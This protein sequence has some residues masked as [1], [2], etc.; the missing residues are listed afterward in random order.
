MRILFGSNNEHKAKEIR[1]IF[2]KSSL[3][4]IE[5]VVPKDLNINLDIEETG[6]TLEE[7]AYLKSEGFYRASGLPSFA[8]DTGL[9]IDALNGEPGVRSARFAGEESNDEKNRKKALRLLSEVPRDKPRTARFRTVI[10]YI[11]ENGANYSVGVCKGK[12]INKERGDNG[13]GYDPI[14]VPEGYDKTF[15]E[16][17]QTEKNKISHRGRAIN[18]FVKF[19]EKR[20]K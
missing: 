15:A 5:I 18:N 2:K 12:I 19:L 10:C 20:L 11:D 17:N 9:E 8:D 7:N 14:F 16:M 3:K 13:F 4:N 6:D 1:N